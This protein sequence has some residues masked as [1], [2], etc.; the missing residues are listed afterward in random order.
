VVSA[1]PQPL[2]CGEETQYPLYRRLG[3]PK[4]WSGWVWKILP[5]PGFKP[6]PVL[7]I[8]SWHTDCAVPAYYGSGFL[9]LY[10]LLGVWL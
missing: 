5:A 4:G 10:T 1:R 2:Y 9:P 3:G 8:P 7:P 6:Q